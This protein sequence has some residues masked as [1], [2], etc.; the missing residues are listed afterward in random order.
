MCCPPYYSEAVLLPN[1]GDGFVLLANANGAA[2]AF[3]GYS[4]IK[5]GL[6]ALL[7]GTA[8]PSRPVTV[9]GIG[10]SMA[11]L[12]LLG[13]GVALLALLRASHS[14]GRMHRRPWWRRLPGLVGPLL[15]GTAAG[16][17][18]GVPVHRSQ[19][20][21]MGYHPRPIVHVCPTAAAACDMPG[22]QA[23]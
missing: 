17:A 8:P 23:T 12:A 22:Q 10:L 20:A 6:I 19:G 3:V 16:S 14:A 2:S 13:A 21:G 15:P 7:R 1:S 4:A 18:I 11:L 9:G 5:Q